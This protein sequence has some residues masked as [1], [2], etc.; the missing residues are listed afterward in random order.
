MSDVPDLF[1]T[2]AKIFVTPPQ[3]ICEHSVRHALSRW[4]WF[5]LGIGLIGQMRQLYILHSAQYSISTHDVDI[6]VRLGRIHDHSGSLR[7]NRPVSGIITR[8]YHTEH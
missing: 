7:V 8:R 6:K 2:Y 4:S 3:D 1:S 5:P